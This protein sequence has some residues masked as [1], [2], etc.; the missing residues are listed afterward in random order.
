MAPAWWAWCS[1]SCQH[2]S[3]RWSQSPGSRSG[4]PGESMQQHLHIT[5]ES[6]CISQVRLCSSTCISRVRV[7][8]STCISYVGNMQQ[9]LHIMCESM[10]QHLHITWESMQQHLHI[11][12]STCSSTCKYRTASKAHQVRHHHLLNKAPPCIFLATLSL[13]SFD[14]NELR[15]MTIPS[16]THAKYQRWAAALL[17]TT[18]HWYSIELHL[19]KYISQYSNPVVCTFFKGTL[20][21]YF[22]C[23]VFC[24]N[25]KYLGPWETNQKFFVFAEIALKIAEEIAC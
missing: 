16:Y 1:L 13:Y 24:M 22:W 11:T 25:L 4:R 10:Q 8:S 3:P 20:A 5:C 6:I 9:H 7:W 12:C 19:L 15:K 17:N 18:V 21:R 23:L 14:P 2:R